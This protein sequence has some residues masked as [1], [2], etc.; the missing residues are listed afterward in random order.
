MVEVKTGPVRTSGYAIK[1]RRVINAALREEYKSGKL[2]S[3][4]VND[5]I[6]ELNKKIY[7]VLVDKFEVPKEA[8]VNITVDVE[9]SGD[10]ITIKKIDVEVWDKDEILSKNVTREVGEKLG[11]KESGGQ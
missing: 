5:A 4:K 1:L 6:T 7:A 11:I 2:D 9:P 10:S 8:V 3:K